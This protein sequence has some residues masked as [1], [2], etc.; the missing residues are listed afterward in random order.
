MIIFGAYE[1]SEISL[2][3]IRQNGEDEDGN[4]IHITTLAFLLFYVEFIKI[5]K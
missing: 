5:Y 1:V 4:E 2:G 3:I